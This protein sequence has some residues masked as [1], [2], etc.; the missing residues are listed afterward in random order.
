[1]GKIIIHNTSSLTDKE[2]INKIY[3]VMALG[4]I[5]ETSGIKHYCH[6]VTFSNDVKVYCLNRKE[7]NNTFYVYEGDV[8]ER[9]RDG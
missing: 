6:V 2:A 7:D 9:W 8:V 4:K 3:S 5:S 1:M